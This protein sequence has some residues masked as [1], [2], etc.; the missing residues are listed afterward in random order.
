[1]KNL[2]IIQD[3]YSDVSAV[4]KTDLSREQAEEKI[5]KVK[6]EYKGEWQFSQ[7][8]E[9]VGQEVEFEVVYV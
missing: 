1:M 9:A 3:E 5:N 2:L 4:V 6:Q 8:T 7:L